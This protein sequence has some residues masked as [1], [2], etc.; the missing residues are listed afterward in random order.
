MSAPYAGRYSLA[1]ENLKEA[2]KHVAADKD[3]ALFHLLCGLQGFIEEL[4]QD[5]SSLWSMI[6]DSPTAKSK[7]AKRKAARS[8][9]AKRSAGSKKKKRVR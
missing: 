4:G 3:P 2:M 5:V 8:S 1:T 7:P 6:G 9:K